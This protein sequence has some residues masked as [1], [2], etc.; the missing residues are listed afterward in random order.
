MTESTKAQP[1]RAAFLGP[2]YWPT[3]LGIG[4][5]R[6]LAP[7]PVAWLVRIGEALGFAVGRLWRKRRHVVR[8]NLSLCFPELSGAQLEQRIDE[9]FRALGTGLFEAA[10]AWWASDAR[11]RRHV[12]FVGVEH[13]DRAMAGGQGVLLLTGHFTT[14]ELGARLV[15]LARPFHPMYRPINNPLI[16]WCMH[17]WRGARAGLPAVPKED[18]RA[19]V[20]ALRAGRAIW[21]APDQ[22][23]DPGSSE[24]VPFFGVPTLT[25]A[26]TSRLA[27]MGRAKVVPY[28]PARVGGRYRISFQPALEDFPGQDARADTARISRVIEEGVRAAPAQYFWVHRRFKHRPKGEK[29]VYGRPR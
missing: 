27:Q 29:D 17:R 24:F 10:L 19:L 15:A 8:V 7:L 13:L 9:H 28:F 3:W 5:L 12:D 20:R 22:T 23:L 14:L 2:R 11:L 16:D 26:A 6:A 4:L 21:Y 25:V 18:L 1:F